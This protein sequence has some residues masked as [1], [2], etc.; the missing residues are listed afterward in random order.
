MA[1]EEGE[2]FRSPVKMIGKSFEKRCDFSR[3]NWAL[4]YWARVPWWSK[5]VLIKKNW[6]F[7]TLKIAH[8]AIR[9]QQLASQPLEGLLGVSESQKYPIF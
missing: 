8:V 2:T 7:F 6:R 3:I 1:L 9:L 4:S 5:W